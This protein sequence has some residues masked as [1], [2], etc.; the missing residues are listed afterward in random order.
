MFDNIDPWFSDTDIRAG[1]TWFGEIQER[2]NASKYGII[3]VT[4]ENLG[5]P[6]LNFEAG[7]LSKTLG[8]DRTLVT[9]LLVKTYRS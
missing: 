2:L 9:P 5:K 4:T 6:W 1:T 8:E 3:V 7:S